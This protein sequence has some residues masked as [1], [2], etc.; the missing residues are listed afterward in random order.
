M[1]INKAAII[2]EIQRTASENS[3]VALGQKTFEKET[4]ISTSVWRGKYWRSWGDALQEAGFAANI[5]NEA[6]EP[7][8]LVLRA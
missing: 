4:G 3:G 6:H 8:F 7:S 1:A 5:P 2:A